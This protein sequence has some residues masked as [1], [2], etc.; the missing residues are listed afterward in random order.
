MWQDK[1]IRLNLPMA[2]VVV[3]L[4][5]QDKVMHMNEVTG[6]Q[7]VEWEQKNSEGGRTKLEVVEEVEK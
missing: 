5:P 2:E 6:A 1:K 7:R 4:R 3:V